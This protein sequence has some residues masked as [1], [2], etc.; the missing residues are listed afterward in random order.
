MTGAN[1]HIEINGEVLRK[2]IS[3]LREASADFAAAARTVPQELPGHALGVLNRAIVIPLANVV[4]DGSREMLATAQM[5]TDHIAEG[6]KTAL[7]SF[8]TVEEDATSLF[9][10]ADE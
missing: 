2:Q 3:L 4:S 8:S 1:Q 10:G 9:S 7:T 6:T 5:L